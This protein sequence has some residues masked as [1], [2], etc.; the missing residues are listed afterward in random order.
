[1]AIVQYDSRKQ[2]AN[3]QW[4]SNNIA[5][6]QFGG[7]AYGLRLLSQWTPKITTRFLV[8]YNNKGY[9]NSLSSIGGVGSKPEQDVYLTYTAS[10]GT[11]VGQ[12]SS[13]A[14]LN[15]LCSV[16]VSPAQKPT[17]TGDVNYYIPK[18]W[19]THELQAGFY[20]EPH[21][22]NKTTTYYANGGG[23]VQENAVLNNPNDPSRVTGFSDAIRQRYRQP[24]HRLHSGKRLCLVCA[25]S[26]ASNLAIVRYRRTAS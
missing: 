9:D 16:S 20:L 3:Y 25:G 22:L 11:L 15:N 19:G 26:L 14:T 6:N 17:I 23:I 13:L 12:G 8:S 18:G 21:E 24:A 1:M 10:A 4:Y 5:I 7:G 2:D